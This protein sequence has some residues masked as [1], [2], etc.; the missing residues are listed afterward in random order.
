MAN[1][2]DKLERIEL[3]VDRIRTKVELPTQAIEEVATAVEQMGAGTGATDIY[4]VA[5]IEERDA[6]AAKEGDTCLVIHPQVFNYDGVNGYDTL[7]FPATVVM[8]TATTINIGAQFKLG[9]SP[10]DRLSYNLTPTWLQV[11]NMKTGTKIADY[12]STDAIT[13]TRTTTE[14]EFKH[15]S[16]LVPSNARVREEILPAIFM[17]CN[18]LEGLFT[19]TGGAWVYAD[20][21]INTTSNEVLPKYNSYS[22]AGPFSGSFP[23]LSTTGLHNVGKAMEAIRNFNVTEGTSLFSG[24]VIE[25][26]LVYVCMLH[27]MFNSSMTNA[28]SMFNASRASGE[29]NLSDIDFSNIKRMSQTFNSMPNIKRLIFPKK[30]SNS[31]ETAEYICAGSSALEYVDASA[32]TVK[33]KTY[34][35]SFFAN[36][37]SLKHIDLRSLDFSILDSVPSNMF[38]GIPTDCL[39]IVKNSSSKSYINRNYSTLTNVKTVAEYGG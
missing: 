38:A 25:D 11:R 26:P 23:E 32:L 33:A 39:I 31:L 3:A 37:T 28:S 29:L 2:S 13:Y 35:T 24:F 16:V 22:S 17:K 5:T 30:M 34:L 36:C 20:I 21:G 15:T 27:M 18:K 8:P 1:L 9:T 4:K 19:Y 10:M 6:I 14:E 7:F 12:T